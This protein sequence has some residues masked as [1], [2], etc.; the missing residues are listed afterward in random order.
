MTP[1]ELT[2]L[3]VISV[4]FGLEVAKKPNKT[5]INKQK[6]YEKNHASNF[7]SRPISKPTASDLQR[8]L[9]RLEKLNRLSNVPSQG[10]Q[11]EQG[12]MENKPMPNA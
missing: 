5:K 6:L 10:D 12:E 4:L 1:I 9:D 3:I 8:L 11:E 7:T 2:I